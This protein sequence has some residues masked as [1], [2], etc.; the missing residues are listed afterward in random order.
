MDININP[1]TNLVSFVSLDITYD[2]SKFEP[3][4]SNAL[5]IN[6]SALPIVLQGPVYAS[7][8]IRINL[9]T[10]NDPTAAIK[11][12]TKVG[13]LTMKA[14]GG[15]GG[16]PASIAFGDSTQV[17]SI[18]GPG[19]GSNDSAG[20][21]VLSTSTPAQITIA[22]GSSTGTT[23]TV[24]PSPTTPVQPTAQPTT[25][26]VPTAIPTTVP[27][28]QDSTEEV[29]PTATSTPSPTPTDEPAAA[30]PTTESG[31]INSTDASATSTPTLEATGPGLTFVSYGAILAVITLIG[32]VLFFA[33]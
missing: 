23:P 27:S 20:E 33:L 31:S 32:A 28:S 9:S 17:L 29:I 8:R 1:G 30:T 25:T 5:V 6:N 16:A 2:P 3:V 18:A 21:N 13:T 11:T 7:G 10:G 19:S 24:N 14:I 15:T 22:G 4:G 26:T 12:P